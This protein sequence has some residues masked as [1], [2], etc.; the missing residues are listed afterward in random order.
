MQTDSI[1]AND[2]SIIESKTHSEKEKTIEIKK[3]IK[4]E[5]NNKEKLNETELEIMANQKKVKSSIRNQTSNSKIHTQVKTTKTKSFIKTNHDTKYTKEETSVVYR[6]QMIKI[7]EQENKSETIRMKKFKLL[8]Q[9]EN[10]G[11]IMKMENTYDELCLEYEK[12]TL[13]KKIKDTANSIKT[14]LVFGSQ[15]ME[16]LNNKYR[17]IEGLDL[18]GWNTSMMYEVQDPKYQDTFYDLAEKW[19]DSLPTLG[20]EISLIIMFATSA[21]KFALAKEQLK[22]DKGPENLNFNQPVNN[23]VEEEEEFKHPPTIVL[24]DII[25]KMDEREKLKEEIIILQPDQANKEKKARGRP[26]KH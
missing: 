22:R 12:L 17:P 26:K 8:Y 2:D 7:A 16:F 15:G 3:E 4:K 1:Q 13:N 21:Y 10:L 11:K 9:L 18:D 14:A 23:I 24:D 5:S 6:K 25:E 20:P 19:S